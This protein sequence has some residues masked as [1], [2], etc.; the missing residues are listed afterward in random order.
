AE[1]A[2][3]T[4]TKMRDEGT[5][6]AWGFGVNN[7]EPCQRALDEADPDIFLLALQYSIV[8]HEDALENLL[9]RCEEQGVW[10]VVGAPFNSGLL[11][12]KQRYNY[13]DKIPDDIRKKAEQISQI[14]LEHGTD[15]RTAALQFSSAPDSVAAV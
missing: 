6:K 10:I 14:A 11:A 3:P 1:G 8:Y 9:P 4:L 12:G 7:I 15:L 5:I 13:D 2:I